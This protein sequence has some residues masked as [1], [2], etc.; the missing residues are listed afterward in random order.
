MKHQKVKKP[1]KK[2]FQT[3]NNFMQDM[4]KEPDKAISYL[5]TALEEYENE[6]DIDGFIISLRRVVEAKGGIGWLSTQTGLNRQNLYK[7]FTHKSQ[8]KF[9]TISIILRSLGFKLA[10]KAG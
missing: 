8:P 2:E 5:E 10:L 3:F 7:I 1:L 4:L 9:N 6:Q